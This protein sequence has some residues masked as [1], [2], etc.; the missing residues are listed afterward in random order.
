MSDSTWGF[1]LLV[2]LLIALPLL[3]V[4][5]FALERRYPGGLINPHQRWIL[6]VVIA[7][8]V[9]SV[10]LLAYAAFEMRRRARNQA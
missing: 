7:L 5:T 9:T 4:G 1:F 3:V 6:F 10:W 8:S 2:L